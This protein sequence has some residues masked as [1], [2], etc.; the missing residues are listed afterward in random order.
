MNRRAEI[1]SCLKNNTT[2][3][4]VRSLRHAPAKDSCCGREGVSA[5]LFEGVGQHGAK[6]SLSSLICRWPFGLKS[7]GSHILW[8][9]PSFFEVFQFLGSK[10]LG[11]F[12]WYFYENSIILW[13]F[14]SHVSWLEPTLKIKEAKPSKLKVSGVSRGL[15]SHLSGTLFPTFWGLL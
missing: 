13:R 12:K 9:C 1:V 6:H 14:S 2:A 4:G 7:R 15:Q 11:Y 8:H 5:P 10:S 3:V